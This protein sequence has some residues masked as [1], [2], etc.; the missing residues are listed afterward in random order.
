MKLHTWC[1][2]YQKSPHKR[3]WAA[4][5]QFM[6]EFTLSQVENDLIL[7]SNVDLWGSHSP[8]S[9]SFALSCLVEQNVEPALLDKDG[10]H[11]AFNSGF[12][13]RG[14]SLS[15]IKHVHSSTPE[16]SCS[17]CS[18]NWE[19][20]YRNCRTSSMQSV[21]LPVSGVLCWSAWKWIRKQ[22]LGKHWG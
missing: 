20:Q 5:V 15:L 9:C 16:Q 7:L 8:L 10:G 13:W 6:N 4:C 22:Q 2:C 18:C 21:G 11:L 19:Q 17:L 14:T 3:N 1:E 12:W